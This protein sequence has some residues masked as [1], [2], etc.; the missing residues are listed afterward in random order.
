MVRARA[1]AIAAQ[2]ATALQSSASPRGRQGRFDPALV[3][4]YQR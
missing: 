1:A 4:K 3:A 2:T